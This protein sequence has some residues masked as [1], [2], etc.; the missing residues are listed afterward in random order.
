[1]GLMLAYLYPLQCQAASFLGSQI[2]PPVFFFGGLWRKGR[3]GSVIHLY[4]GASSMKKLMR[5]PM[6]C[7]AVG[8]KKLSSWR[9]RSNGQHGG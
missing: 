8:E 4:P 2:G 1:M 9:L 3:T 6:P 5:P 7:P